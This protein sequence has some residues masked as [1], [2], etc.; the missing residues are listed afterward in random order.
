MMLHIL[1]S[2]QGRTFQMDSLY[3]SESTEYFISL[4]RAFKLEHTSR[5]HQF[6]SLAQNQV[7]IKIM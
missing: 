7:S 2:L 4:Q 3:S 6:Q 1:F 5:S